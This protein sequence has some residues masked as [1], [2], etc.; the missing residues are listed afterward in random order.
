MRNK[1]HDPASSHSAFAEPGVFHG[2]VIRNEAASW[3]VVGSNSV[4][5]PASSWAAVRMNFQTEEA[6]ES[7]MLRMAERTKSGRDPS[8]ANNPPESR[9]LMLRA[10]QPSTSGMASISCSNPTRYASS[11]EMRYWRN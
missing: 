7:F 8:T 3:K 11:G 5:L 9:V 10:G 2:H 6:C 4:R 1:A